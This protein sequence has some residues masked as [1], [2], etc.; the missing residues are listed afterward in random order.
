MSQKYKAI[1]VITLFIT[2]F[3][4]AQKTGSAETL[5]ECWMTAYALR[6][7]V[8]IGLV[9]HFESEMGE[10]FSDDRDIPYYSEHDT[11]ISM[12]NMAADLIDCSRDYNVEEMLYN[13]NK[14]FGLIL[15]VA[16]SYRID[17]NVFSRTFEPIVEEEEPTEV[18]T[19]QEDDEVKTQ[20][21]VVIEDSKY[22]KCSCKVVGRKYFKSFNTGNMIEDYLKMSMYIKG[23]GLPATA[24][25]HFNEG[26]KDVLKSRNNN[27]I[28]GYLYKDR[29]ISTD[30]LKKD[31][32]NIVTLDGGIPVLMELETKTLDN[33][34]DLIN[35]SLYKVKI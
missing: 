10:D 34:Y 27:I 25:F 11:T 4:N 20:I 32:N 3:I 23:F 28:M 8:S 17:T 24:G 30:D 12:L 5:A 33:F 29:I 13:I 22:V 2:R 9:T 6:E 26:L 21:R 18:V 19:E 15:R 14:M 7:S 1:D 16:E 35:K 31:G